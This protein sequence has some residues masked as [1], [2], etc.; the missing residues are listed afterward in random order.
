[1]MAFVTISSTQG[2]PPERRVAHIGGPLQA[3]RAC[4]RIG[5]FFTCT[6]VFASLGA[7]RELLKI[8]RG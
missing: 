4:I 2:P 1:M 7:E 6:A 5:R 3:P 8:E